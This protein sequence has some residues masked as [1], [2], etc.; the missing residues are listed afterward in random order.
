MSCGEAVER[1][2][3]HVLS[4]RKMSLNVTAENN[5]LLDSER[6]ARQVAELMEDEIAVGI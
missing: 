4:K 6:I 2:F 1:A 3:E 5:I